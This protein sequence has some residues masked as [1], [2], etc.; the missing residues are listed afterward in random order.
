[1]ASGEVNPFFQAASVA[2]ATTFVAHYMETDIKKQGPDVC[3]CVVL[4]E[5]P[6]P[7]VT[8]FQLAF[9]KDAKAKFGR[10]RESLSPDPADLVLVVAALGFSLTFLFGVNYLRSTSESETPSL[11]GLVDRWKLKKDNPDLFRR[12]E[13]LHHFFG[14]NLRHTDAG[15]IQLKLLPLNA[16][17]VLRFMKTTQDLWRWFI[18][19]YYDRFGQGTVPA[20][21]FDEFSERY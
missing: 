21:Q 4:T 18:H 8:N 17:R 20:G 2:P 7:P 14:Q 6:S 11:V 12:F 5:E 16:D 15:K 13:E 10:I 3:V 9:W 19:A 1:M